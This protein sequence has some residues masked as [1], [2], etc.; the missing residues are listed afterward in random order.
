MYDARRVDVWSIGTLLAYSLS[1]LMPFGAGSTANTTL[2]QAVNQW[3]SFKGGRH[4]YVFGATT[5]ALVTELLT[6]FVFVAFEERI[7]A[8]KLVEKLSSQTLFRDC[9][10]RSAEAVKTKGSRS[11][12]RPSSR[13]VQ[14][15][16][17]QPHHRKTNP[18]QTGKGGTHTLSHS[19]K[20]AESKM[21]QSHFRKQA[22]K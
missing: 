8:E 13:G 11:A 12:S 3:A 14:S 15:K 22:K 16:H 17:Q 18:R 10:R 1:G 2:E 5:V 7:Q 6:K 21:K 19:S 9:Q 4:S 20:V